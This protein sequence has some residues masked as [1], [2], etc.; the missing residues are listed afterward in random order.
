MKPFWP[1]ST[2]LG[3]NIW[4]LY[5]Y[6]GAVTHSVRNIPHHN[7]S[8]TAHFM[9]P[10]RF[11]FHLQ[12]ANNWLTRDDNWEQQ[13][14]AWHESSLFMWMCTGLTIKKLNVF[15]TSQANAITFHPKF[16]FCHIPDAHFKFFGQLDTRATSAGWISKAKEFK[17]RQ[18]WQTGEAYFRLCKL[19]LRGMRT[20]NVTVT[21]RLA[22][23]GLRTKGKGIV[24]RQCCPRFINGLCVWYVLFLSFQ[25][26]T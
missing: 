24:P 16:T 6:F 9:G 19:T 15:G 13:Q 21:G 11:C 7:F 25:L 14:V 5:E 22:S 10:S 12:T 2:R 17:L 26:I 23:F 20:A 4:C 1:S 18:R 3:G 8:L